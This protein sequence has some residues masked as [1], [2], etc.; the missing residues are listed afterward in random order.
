MKKLPVEVEVLIISIL[1]IRQLKTGDFYF[2]Q[3]E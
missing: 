2:T 1:Q 3:R